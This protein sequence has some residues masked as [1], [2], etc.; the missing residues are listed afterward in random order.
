M[1]NKITF[2]LLSFVICFLVFSSLW[3]LST[4]HRSLVFAADDWKTKPFTQWSQGEAK[5]ITTN[6][7]WTKIGDVLYEAQLQRS[8]G[9]VN[10]Q[11]LGNLGGDNPNRAVPFQLTW[12]TKIPRQ[13]SCRQLQ[14]IQ[15]F[16]DEEAAR[17]V[18]QDKPKD[19]WK[20]IFKSSLAMAVRQQADDA[21]Q[22]ITFLKRDDGV[23]LQVAQIE[24]P[25]GSGYVNYLFPMYLPDGSA[26]IN[27]STKEFSFETRV[28]G[29]LV[30]AKFKVADCRLNGLLEP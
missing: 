22:A 20:F 19:Q 26:F 11:N 15:K 29:S 1:K 23:K 7:P 13:A 24:D 10:A 2:F 14:L 3:T 9:R 12:Y 25:P 17:M 4:N 27:D 6:S 8:Q 30:R 21:A 16:S 28:R 18:E 5:K